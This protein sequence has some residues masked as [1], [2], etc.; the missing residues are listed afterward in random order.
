MYYISV[1]KSLKR[2]RESEKYNKDWRG[3]YNNKSLCVIFPENRNILSIIVKYCFEENI[4]IKAINMFCFI[5]RSI[6]LKSY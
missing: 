6:N 1:Q 5:K 3:F 4:K 2:E